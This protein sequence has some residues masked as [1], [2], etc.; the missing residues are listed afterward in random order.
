MSLVHGQA[1]LPVAGGNDARGQIL[2]DHRARTHDGVLA[3][4]DA[5]TD[6]DA[7]A[8]PDVVGERD[9]L[10]VLPSDP[11]RL[12]V[13]GMRRGEQWTLV[14]I[15]QAAPTVIG[16]TS[17]ISAPTLTNVRSPMPIAPYSQ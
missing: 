2:G 10:A 3:D 17:S 14:A 9:R 12:R 11:A 13:D 6:D 16:A 5:G 15:W 8:E 4:R 1:T 7:A